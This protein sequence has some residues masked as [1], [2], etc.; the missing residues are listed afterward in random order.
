MGEKMRA[1][2]YQKDASVV[3]EEMDRPQAGPG[4]LLVKTYACGVCVADTME[5]YNKKKAPIVLGHEAVGTVAGLGNGVEGFREGDRV[6]VH[7]HVACMKCD[8]CQKGHYTLCKQF[9]ATKYAPGG[10]A[11]YFKATKEHVELDTLKLPE[12][13]SFEEA[14]LIEPLACAIH[15]VRKLKVRPEDK[16]AVIGAGTIGLMFVEI[17]RAYGVSDI[18]VYE[19]LEWRQE[20]ARARGA[21]VRVALPELEEEKAALQKELGWSAF[22]KVCVI[23]KDIRAMEI[24]VGLTGMGS[25][26]LL[27]ATPAPEE[28]L[29]FYVSD[30]FFKELAVHLSYSA[31]HLDTREAMRLIASGKVDAA[32]YITHV[33]PLE[34]LEEAIRQTAGRDRCLKCIVKI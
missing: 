11:E 6:F 1:A 16:V 26:L 5:W 12:S 14:T 15:A 9:K 8:V 10:F 21:V 30:A 19:M 7:H 4:E 2:V 34:G 3:V 29:K 24:G 13:M 31:D 32:S 28:Y 18:V 22:D 23:A 27:F 33:Y 17:L 25:D 20:Q